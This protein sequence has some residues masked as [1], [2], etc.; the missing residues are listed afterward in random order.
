[1]LSR[2]DLEFIVKKSTAQY[3][4]INKSKIRNYI[5]E[6]I[7]CILDL[8]NFDGIQTALEAL[9]IVKEWGGTLTDDKEVNADIVYHDIIT[10]RM[11]HYTKSINGET[12]PIFIKNYINNMRAGEALKYRRYVEEHQPGMDL[13][14]DVQIPE[15]DGGGSFSTFLGI[16]DTIFITL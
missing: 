14:I 8:E 2:E 12:N 16:Q 4:L 15:S 7:T 11:I 5:D 13:K 1:M 3:N 9:D 10:S 6:L